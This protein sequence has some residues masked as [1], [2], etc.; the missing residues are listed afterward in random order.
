M[1][2]E[3]QPKQGLETGGLVSG[4]EAARARV[5][6]NYE[7]DLAGKNGPTAR[8]DTFRELIGTEIASALNE[9]SF[10]SG[11]GSQIFGRG[12][13]FA[14]TASTPKAKK[15]VVTDT[16]ASKAARW[17]IVVTDPDSAAFE[18]ARPGT[19]LKDLT[20]LEDPFTITS[21]ASSFT[22]GD[23]KRLRLKFAGA[24]D[25]MTVTLECATNP[26][27]F[28]AAVETTGSGNTAEF[29]NYYFY[30]WDFLSTPPDDTYVSIGNGI[31]GKKLIG[32]TSYVRVGPG[33][34]KS[35]DR[36]YVIP[37]LLPYHDAFV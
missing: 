7:D 26:T 16:V 22:A 37:M 11:D 10:S 33:Y 24:F 36:P 19:I 9:M 29:T 2:E 3:A 31:F 5:A 28:P 1:I 8:F 27:D 6:L 17:D 25:S 12:G 35:G 21:V 4:S 14:L 23:G 15:G 20:D 30:L 13:R 32:D 18:L 34:H